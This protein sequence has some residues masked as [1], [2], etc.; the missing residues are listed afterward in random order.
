MQMKRYEFH[1]ENENGTTSTH[2]KSRQA[3]CYAQLE[4]QVK[5]WSANRRCRSPNTKKWRLLLKHIQAALIF[6]LALTATAFAKDDDKD[7]PIPIDQLPAKVTA[8][9]KRVAGVH[10]FD[11][12]ERKE[13]DGQV[14]FK[15]KAETESHSYRFEISEAG[16]LLKYE[17]K[18]EKQKEE[19]EIDQLPASI[20]DAATK[21]V[22]NIEL[23]DAERQTRGPVTIYE[24]EGKVDGRRFEIKLTPKGKVIEVV[25]KDEEKARK[26]AEKKAEEDAERLEKKAKR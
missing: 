9:A 24:V 22:K 15:L 10:T 1:Q 14:Y 2:N 12:A 3:S 25:D 8:E 5:Y 17:M 13:K 26:E 11:E 16:E 20:R 4:N 23:K 21:A 7:K 6:T 19:L 18:Y